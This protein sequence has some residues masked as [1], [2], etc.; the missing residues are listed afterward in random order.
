M[1]N[2]TQWKAAD[3]SHAL[4]WRR[5]IAV[6]PADAV[7][8]R[9]GDLF[10]INE[11]WG[12][13]LLDANVLLPLDA[14]RAQA[15]AGQ[16]AGG[17]NLTALAM[18]EQRAYAY[19]WVIKNGTAA[20]APS[21][22]PFV[23]LNASAAGTQ[24][25]LAKMPYLRESRRSQYGIGQ[26]RLCHD[27][28]AVNGTGPGGPG[29]WEPADDARAAPGS[30]QARKDAT[31]FRWVD[32][33]GIGSYGF[34]LHHFRVPSDACP[35]GYPSYL[36]YSP[37]PGPALPYYLRECCLPRIAASVMPAACCHRAH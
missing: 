24:T 4:I 30:D 7:N 20:A 22:L 27:F 10:L 35:N 37:D 5:S 12:N 18:A 2:G 8:P 29:C 15:Q 6:D 32:T 25:G 9:Q 26:F 21:A 34:D 36:E 1:P 23:A 31:G 11:Q 19:Y 33:V 17:M 28:A 14:A 16:W 13:D 3:L